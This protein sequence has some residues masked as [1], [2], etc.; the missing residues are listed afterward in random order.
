MSSR[1]TSDGP[2]VG[3]MMRIAVEWIRAQIYSD[4]VA[5]G[6][7]D[8]TPAHVRV[9]SYPG[10]DGR[11]PS[12][13]AETLQIT[14][15]SVNELLGHLERLGYLSRETDPADGR[16]RTLRL[17]AKGRELQVATD[18]AAYAA[19]RRVAELLGERRFTQFRG[20]LAELVQL[21]NGLS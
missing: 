11:R 5:A 4:V 3:G 16:A 9:F 1:I 15:Q 10:P 20:G 6:H 14:K 7:E 17:T 19:E 21:I 18:R 13:V 2:Y 12:E 8:L